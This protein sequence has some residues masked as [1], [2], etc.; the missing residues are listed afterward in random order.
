MNILKTLGMVAGIG[1]IAFGVLLLIFKEIIGKDIFPRLTS[2]EATKLLRMLV[3]LTWVIAVLGLA[4]W[5]YLKVINSGN[6]KPFENDKH[7]ED[8]KPLGNDEK[9][10]SFSR[11]DFVARYTFF[12][13]EIHQQEYQLIEGESETEN[14]TDFLTIHTLTFDTVLEV[15]KIELLLKNIWKTDVIIDIQDKYFR[16]EDDRGI[17]AVLLEA[18]FPAQS[19]ILPPTGVRRIELFYSTRGWQRKQGADFIIFYIEGFLPIVRASWKWH[20][21]KALE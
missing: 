16:L 20:S 12:S 7:V 14:I 8:D 18:Q 5:T 19:T 1:G 21:L 15:Y 3:I 13:E 6:E 4:S 9:K 11:D 10:S 2:K 17:K